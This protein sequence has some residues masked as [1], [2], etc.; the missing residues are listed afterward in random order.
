MSHPRTRTAAIVCKYLYYRDRTAEGEINLVKIPSVTIA[1]KSESAWYKSFA[2]VDSG[3]YTTFLQKEEADLLGLK[4]AKDPD[5]SD[6]EGEA[7]GAGGT[8]KCDIKVIPEL[9]V[10]DNKERPFYTY[11]G[12][13]VFVP[14]DSGRIP[15]PILGR[16]TIFRHFHI[17]FRE[18]QKDIVFRRA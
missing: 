4:N 8:F 5:G 9:T 6:S 7:V 15:Y 2:L 14:K 17:T 13:R 12:I 16:D 18:G 11:R 1:L 3:A 10:M